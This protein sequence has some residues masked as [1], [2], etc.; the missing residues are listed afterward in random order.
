VRPWSTVLR[1]PTSNGD[2]YFKASAPGFAH[3]PATL[4]V[5]A[6]RRPH[7]VPRP[8]A[9]D[10]ECGWMLL[11]DLGSDGG[12]RL[13]ETLQADRDLAHWERLLPVYAE[14]QRT[15]AGQTT[16]LL[17][18][19]VPDRHPDDLPARF[20]YLLAD[21]T[22]NLS[23]DERADLCALA[24]RVSALCTALSDGAGSVPATSLDHGDLHDGNIFVKND[25][26]RR[27]CY[28]FFDWGDCAVTH[29]FFSL[30]GVF[31]SLENTL[32][33]A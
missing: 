26:R 18:L 3:E 27:C 17:A 31:V 20:E 21:T 2:V 8:L 30:R 32:G 25:G 9:T 6:R 14:L 28:V 5:L 15:V 11:D 19:D 1:A 7:C 22:V 16:E 13:R 23:P 12:A 33:L 10:I 4:L 29:P 24:P